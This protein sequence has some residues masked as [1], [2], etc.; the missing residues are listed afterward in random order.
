MEESFNKKI[1]ILAHHSKIYH[2]TH[3]TFQHD[4]SVTHFPH[5]TTW[6]CGRKP[7]L[8]FANFA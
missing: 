5:W 3:I 4:T 8:A 6:Q 1:L 2:K 7:Q